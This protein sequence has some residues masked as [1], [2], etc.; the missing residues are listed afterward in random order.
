MFLKTIAISAL[1]LGT[2]TAAMA[3]TTHKTHT[4]EM[5]KGPRVQSVIGSGQDHSKDAILPDGTINVDPSVTGSINRTTSF[6]QPRLQCDSSPNTSEMRSNV[7]DAASS[8]P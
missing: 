2:A 3:Q 5:F 7:F 8:C 6:S 1:A 4:T